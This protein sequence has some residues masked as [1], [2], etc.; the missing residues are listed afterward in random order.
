MK[1]MAAIQKQLTDAKHASVQT[2]ELLKHAHAGSSAL[3]SI[4]IMPL[5]KDA[6]AL[7]FQLSEVVQAMNAHTR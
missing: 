3:Q 7:V 4:V 5:L 2:L 1:T 6:A